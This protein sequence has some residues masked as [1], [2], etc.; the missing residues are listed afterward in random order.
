MNQELVQQKSHNNSFMLTV[1]VQQ[2][3]VVELQNH[4]TYIVHSYGVVAVLNLHC[5]QLR[6]WAFIFRGRK[7]FKGEKMIWVK[8]NVSEDMYS[9][10]SA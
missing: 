10:F 8:P 6:I 9:H 2:I 4:N 5:E 7:N 3:L 1:K